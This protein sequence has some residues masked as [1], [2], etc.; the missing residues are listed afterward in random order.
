MIDDKGKEKQDSAPVGFCVDC[1]YWQHTG[2]YGVDGECIAGASH[3]TPEQQYF[4][5]G[6]HITGPGYSCAQF[7]LKLKSFNA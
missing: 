2:V 7:E 5:A 6:G 3:L 1:C 4:A